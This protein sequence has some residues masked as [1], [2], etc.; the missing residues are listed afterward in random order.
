MQRVRRIVTYACTAC[1]K[2]FPDAK[3]AKEH[4]RSHPLPIKAY[5]RPAKRR[6]T[7]AGSV[8]EAVRA[9]AKT[10]EAVTKKTKIPIQRVHTLLSYH[11]RRGNVKGF[12]GTL[13]AA[14]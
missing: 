8:L 10:A 12:S 7:Q 5:A 3:S 1:Y 4:A 9:G 13:K 11:R 2:L 14:R 6:T